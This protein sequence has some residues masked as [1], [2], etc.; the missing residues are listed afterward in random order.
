MILDLN[1]ND[2]INLVNKL[3]QEYYNR[4]SKY[5]EIEKYYKGKTKAKENYKLT[6]RS[7]RKA[8]IN[9]IKKFVQ[10]ET[11]FAVGN[12]ITYS[13]KTGLTD[14]I[15]TINYVIKGQKSILDIELA[16]VLGKFGE[17]Y[18]LRYL[19]N[20]E[21]KI[22]VIEPLNAIAYCNNE[23]EVELF[24]YFYTKELDNNVYIDII[25]DTCIYSFIKDSMIPINTV[26]HYFASVPVGVAKFVNS[27]DDTIYSDIHELQDLYEMAMWDNCN[28]IADLR[29]SYLCLSGASIEE[30]D[31][32]DMKKLGIIQLPQANS[33]AEWLQKNLEGDFCN[34]LI[35]KL[36]DLIYQLSAHINHNV[37]MASNTSGVALSSR[38]I[39][40]RNKVIT[41]QKCLENCIRSRLR[42]ICTYYNISENKNYDYKDINIIFT[43]NLPQDDVSMAQ[44]ITQLN[45]KLSAETG[46][47]QLSFITDG[48]NEYT[49]AIEEQKQAINITNLDLDT[50]VSKLYEGQ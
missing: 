33:K 11:S 16:N 47:N 49:K 23:D 7:N 46:L 48:K 22:K 40:L 42:D 26:K 34:S 36:E 29:S 3:Q 41:L 10:E 27:V 8:S 17:A 39:S 4:L 35:N 1:N 31:V 9:Y 24:L 37:A 13:S 12:D 32:K 5:R 14:E 6:D 44:I 28:N 25:D 15:D 19:Y 18:E 38:L 50:E 30:E 45:G 2:H 43:M 20:G 21:L